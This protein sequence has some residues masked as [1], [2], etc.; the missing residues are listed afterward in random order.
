MDIN[1][2]LIK[3]IISSDELCEKV[4]STTYRDS[5]KKQIMR[6]VLYLCDDIKTNISYINRYLKF[7]V[8]NNKN[9]EDAFFDPVLLKS[10]SK[11]ISDTDY[12]NIIGGFGFYE[13]KELLI[14]KYDQIVKSGTYYDIIRMLY[15]YMY[16]CGNMVLPNNYIDYF[17]K[18][19]ILNDLSFRD[20]LIVYFYKQFALSYSLSRG[21]NIKFRVVQEI[22]K[23]DPYYDN[24]KN[25]ISIYRHEITNR[26]NYN[27][28]ASIF[29]QIKYL[30]ILKSINDPDNVVYSFEQLRLVKELCVVSL[31]GEDEFNSNYSHISM[32]NTLH[33]ES[34][35]TLKSYFNK[36]G[37]KV[38]IDSVLFDI[39]MSI[40]SI[41]VLFDN[42]LNSEGPNL[43]KSLIKNYPVLACEYKFDRKKSLLNLLLDIYSNRKL[44]VNLNKDLDWYRT[45]NDNEFAASKIKRLENKISVCESCISVMNLIVNNGDFLLDDLLRSISDLI[46]HNSS[47]DYVKNDIYAVL[48]VVV[49]RKVRKMCR[50]K[51]KEYIEETRKK[52]IECYMKSLG[53]VRN[54]MDIDYFMKLYSTLDEINK[55]F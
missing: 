14:K 37:V 6:F 15:F 35:K 51:D 8:V 32:S 41:D 13:I 46:L 34:H 21:L 25:E 38:N 1:I 4:N 33:Q 3:Q 19:I 31:I 17:T 45:K 48:K 39:D 36:L 26:L 10:Y 24:R 29:A 50:G 55:I 43:L 18:Y 44:L 30:Y 28:L 11:D 20:D 27:V 22:T 42:V 49:P 5:Y 12:L 9:K 53:T 7:F 23:S 47:K 40:D 2:D 54:N 16:I 52:I